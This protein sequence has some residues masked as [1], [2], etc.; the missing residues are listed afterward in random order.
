M[1]KCNILIIIDKIKS[2]ICQSGVSI[3]RNNPKISIYL[4][5]MSMRS[6]YQ[7]YMS[8]KYESLDI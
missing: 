6:R 2:H 4:F 5:D 8:I 7:I 3:C 1:T